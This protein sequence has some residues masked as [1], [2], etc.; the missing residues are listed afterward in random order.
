MFGS[1]TVSSQES[2]MAY[3]SIQLL[4]LPLKRLTKYVELLAAQYTM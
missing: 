4:Y 3:L 2:K 1:E